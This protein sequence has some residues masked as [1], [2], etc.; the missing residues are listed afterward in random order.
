MAYTTESYFN[1]SANTRSLCE[2]TSIV[3]NKTFI[4]NCLNIS[5]LKRNVSQVHAVV[6]HFRQDF[7]INIFIGFF[8]NKKKKNEDSSMRC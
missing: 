5:K 6:S 1:G 3:T 7:Y 2:S 8:C 4:Y